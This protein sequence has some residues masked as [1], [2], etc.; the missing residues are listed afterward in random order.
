MPDPIEKTSTRN[1]FYDEQGKHTRTKKEILD[2]N[3]NIR[4]GCKVVK[5][6]E[7]Y[8]RN[9]FTAK[10]ISDCIRE[11]I[12]VSGNKEQVTEWEKIYGMDSHKQDKEGVLE[13]L[14][15][16]H[17]ISTG[18]QQQNTVKRKDRGAR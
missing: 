7:I 13:R 12:D 11:S 8:E 4:K 2:E 15:N 14:M 3:G 1:M 6:D 17:Q 5:K 16:S 18:Y 10:N 9:I